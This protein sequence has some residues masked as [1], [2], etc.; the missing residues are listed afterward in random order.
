[1]TLHRNSTVTDG[2][3]IIHAYEYADD[4]ARLAATGFVSTDIGKVARVLSTSIFWILTNHSP[5]TW[6]S[7]GVSGGAHGALTG[8]SSDDHTQ[9]LLVSGTRA[10]TGALDMG[11]QAITSVGNVDG[12]DVS[13]D[14]TKLDT[15]RTNA[16]SS[17][18]F[19]GNGSVSNSTT[20]RYLTPG[21]GD[22]TAPTAPQQFRMAYPGKYKNL[23]LRQNN[24]AGN[25]NNIVYTLRVNNATTALTCTIASTANDASDLVNIITVA[26]GDLIDIQVTKASSVGTAPQ[27][28]TLEVELAST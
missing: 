20:T 19:W 14:G 13:V 5:I 21:W 15:I 4:T 24:P 23:R 26:A 27:D 3:H 12:R 16:T 9:Y 8:L 28:V 1:M 17:Y 10:M 22:A 18:R 25:G 2:N 11:S 7:A 6:S